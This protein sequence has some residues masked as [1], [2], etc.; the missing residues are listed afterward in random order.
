MCVNRVDPSPNLFLTGF[1]MTLIKYIIKLICMAFVKEK[2]FM[3]SYWLCTGSET[4]VCY[5]SKQKNEKI[6]K[7]LN[8]RNEFYP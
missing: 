7:I 8:F 3:P 4:V 1:S 5:F 2:P 6:K